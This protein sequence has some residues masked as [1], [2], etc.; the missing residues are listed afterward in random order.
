MS[1]REKRAVEMRILLARWEK[2]G[3]SLKAFSMQ[4]GV[5]YTTLAYWRR[6][7]LQGHPERSRRRSSTASKTAPAARSSSSASDLLPVHVLSTEGAGGYELRLP[8][9]L[10][11]RLPTGFQSSEVRRLL[12]LARTC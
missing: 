7:E 6:R 1:K 5:P 8:G 12:E 10:E 3:A 9:G 4:E 2:S 11:I